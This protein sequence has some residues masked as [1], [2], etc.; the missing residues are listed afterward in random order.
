M[1][2]TII[3]EILVSGVLAP[4]SFIDFRLSLFTISGDLAVITLYCLSFA[5]RTLNSDLH[6]FLAISRLKSKR[7]EVLFGASSSRIWLHLLFAFSFLQ[8]PEGAEKPL[9]CHS[10]PVYVNFDNVNSKLF[11]QKVRSCTKTLVLLFAISLAWTLRNFLRT[12]APASGCVSVSVALSIQHSNSLT[13]TFL[14][15]LCS[16]HV[17]NLEDS[18]AELAFSCFLRVVRVK[19]LCDVCKLQVPRIFCNSSFFS[20]YSLV[21]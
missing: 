13:D 4:H 3:A 19:L 9:P 15:F 14:Y 6:S 21:W 20:Q 16:E 8:F 5:C 7:E 12:R 10:P 11:A 18:S 1:H 2:I 17:V